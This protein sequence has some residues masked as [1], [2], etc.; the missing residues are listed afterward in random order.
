MILS[1]FSLSLF[2]RHASYTDHSWS[3]ISVTNRGGFPLKLAPLKIFFCFIF[4]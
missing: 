4:K 2:I 3:R 1:S